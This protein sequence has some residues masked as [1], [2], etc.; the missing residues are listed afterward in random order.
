[1]PNLI[2]ADVRFSDKYSLILFIHFV[3]SLPHVFQPTLKNANN[4]RKSLANVMILLNMINSFNL[5]RLVC[6]ILLKL[7][8][9]PR[10]PEELI[11]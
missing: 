2:Q 7:I 6:I 3:K 5:Y 4:Q 1:M 10:F 9:Q 8:N 11:Y